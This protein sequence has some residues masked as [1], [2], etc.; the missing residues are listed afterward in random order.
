MLGKSQTAQY[1]LTCFAFS[2]EPVHFEHEGMFSVSV[3]GKTSTPS[4]PWVSASEINC[5]L[6]VH[7]VGGTGVRGPQRVMRREGLSLRQSLL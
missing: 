2:P 6:V 4:Q 5:T 3:L 7:S 1:M